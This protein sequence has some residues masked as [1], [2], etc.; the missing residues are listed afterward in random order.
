MTSLF[1]HGPWLILFLAFWAA[2]FSTLGYWQTSKIYGLQ[3]EQ[4]CAFRVYIT[5]V[6]PPVVEDTATTMSDTVET[7]IGSF[8]NELAASQYGADA[9]KE[10][11]AFYADT[12]WFNLEQDCTRTDE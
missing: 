10:A 7:Y 2:A 11:M 5:T 12:A 3:K 1:K 4:G 9:A 6:S 8:R